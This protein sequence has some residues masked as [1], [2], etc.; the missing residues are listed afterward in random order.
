MFIVSVIGEFV[1]WEERPV[2][3]L[4]QYLFRRTTISPA[5]KRRIFFTCIVLQGG[6]SLW[7][8]YGTLW[9]F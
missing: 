2:I 9:H 8:P 5:N 7:L 4:F 6:G 3:G 1:L